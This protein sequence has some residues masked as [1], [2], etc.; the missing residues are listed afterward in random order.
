MAIE[1]N[2]FARTVRVHF[3][4]WDSKYDETKHIDSDSMDIV[5]RHTKS[6]N[7]RANMKVS[8][9]CVCGVL[10]VWRVV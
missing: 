4:G 2:K 7:W 10:Y 5:P 8:A 3:L 1:T 9:C 6:H